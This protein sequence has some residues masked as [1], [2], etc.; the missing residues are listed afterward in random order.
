MSYP[1][2]PKN[3]KKIYLDYAAATPVDPRVVAKM[4]P[5]FTEHFGNPSALYASGVKSRGDEDSARAKIAK[6][7]VARPDEII[8]T[9]GGT[10]ANNLSIFGVT[11]A[12]R[13]H[14]RH[15]VTTN[16]EHHSILEPLKKLEIAG[17][18]VTYL[19]TKPDGTLDLKQIIKSIRPDTI[20]I[21]IMYAN[22]EIGTVNDIAGI[23]RE[24]L[25]LRKQNHSIYP[26][27]HTDACQAAGLLDLSVNKLHVDLMTVNSSKIYGPKGI[28]IL[29]KRRGVE[30]TPQILGGSQEGG[31]RGGTENIPGII[32]IAEALD[33]SQKNKDAEGKRLRKLIEYFWKKIQ[34]IPDVKL[35]GR[36]ESRLPNNLNVCVKGIEGE[37]LVLYLSEYGIECATGS[38][39]AAADAEPSHVLRACG[40]DEA[41]TR[42]S[43]RFTIG[44]WTR[45]T[46]IDYA[47]KYLPEIIK[48][49]RQASKLK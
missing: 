34:T 49:L 17:F 43:I 7:L 22:N 23:G 4:R 35:N 40:L 33:I 46:D 47:L 14:G 16:I 9:G 18:T 28:G 38:A 36:L 29:Y 24:I 27:F 30:L 25:K 11:E 37:A 5:Y 3:K 1:K 2:R 13:R 19:P 39:C 15:I 21:S 26:F 44:R 12:H 48:E 41:E 8:F 10:E 6:I 45:K 42:G 20:L 31:Q 32:G